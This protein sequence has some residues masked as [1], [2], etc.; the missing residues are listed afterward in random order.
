LRAYVT[1]LENPAGSGAT[2]AL[3]AWQLV[4][5]ISEDMEQEEAGV[6]RSRSL[7]GDA[8]ITDAESC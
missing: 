5:L 1:A 7:L 8:G 3:I 2:L 6:L 4:E